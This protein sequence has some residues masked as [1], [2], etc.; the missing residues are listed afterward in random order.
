[1]RQ[2]RVK[3][4]RLGFHKIHTVRTKQPMRMGAAFREEG[5]GTFFFLPSVSPI[6]CDL[7]NFMKLKTKSTH[8]LH[9]WTMFWAAAM[10]TFTARLFSSLE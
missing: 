3:S 5:T 8:Q 6:L 1:M 7:L 2:V 9:P 4:T 10:L